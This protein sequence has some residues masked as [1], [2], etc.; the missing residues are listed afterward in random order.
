MKCAVVLSVLFAGCSVLLG[1]SPNSPSPRRPAS[2][3]LD[4]LVRMTRTGSSDASVLAYARA[5]RLELAPEVSDANLRWLRNSGVSERVVHYMAA[6]DVRGSDVGPPEGVT[7]AADEDERPARPRSAYSSEIDDERDSGSVLRRD[8]ERD[9]G[10]YGDSYRASDAYADYGYD[11]DYAYNPYF[12]YPYPY[13]FFPPYFI[14]R[15]DFFRRFPRRDRRDRRDHRFDGGHRGAVAERGR[16]HESWRDRGSRGRRGDFLARDSRGFG[17]PSFA[18]GLP[19]GAS[20][21]RGR[22]VG[23]RG[24]GPSGWGRA[25]SSPGFHG[26]PGGGAVTGFRHSAPAGGSHP[27]GGGGSNRGAPGVH[28]GGRGRR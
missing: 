22:T 17:R 25:P 8:V 28:G 21:G 27:R 7:E 6:I 13:S 15:G 3:L 1:D 16:F 23:Q 19:P 26:S 2:A 9:A 14:G 24:S 20:G 10:G 18:H 5:H 4:D 12:G 11:L